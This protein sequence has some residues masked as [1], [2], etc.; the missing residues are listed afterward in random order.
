MDIETL[1][2][3]ANK[4]ELLMDGTT[5]PVIAILNSAAVVYAVWQDHDAPNGVATLVLKGQKALTAQDSGKALSV[6]AVKVL[7]LEMAVAAR[8]TLGEAV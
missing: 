6:N 1:V 4:N 5:K 7:D 2:A 8:Q 3:M